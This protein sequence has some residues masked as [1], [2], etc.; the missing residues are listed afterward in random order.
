MRIVSEI[1]PEWVSDYKETQKGIDGFRLAGLEH[2]ISN[3]NSLL[4]KRKNPNELENGVDE[5]VVRKEKIEDAKKRFLERKK[6]KK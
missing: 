6:V 3:P 2:T 4:N 5:E 1:K